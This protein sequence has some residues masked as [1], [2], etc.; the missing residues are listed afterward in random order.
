MCVWNNRINQNIIIINMIPLFIGRSQIHNQVWAVN[1]RLWKQTMTDDFAYQIINE[2]ATIVSQYIE[3]HS[4]SVGETL[5]YARRCRRQC[6]NSTKYNMVRS[7]CDEMPN[8]SSVKVLPHWM[9]AISKKCVCKV[10][11]ARFVPNSV[12]IRKLH[13]PLCTCFL[14]SI[15]IKTVIFT[16]WSKIDRK[17]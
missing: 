16:K 12:A 6:R 17:K 13:G 15:Q 14:S 2:T 5:F 7:W 11:L 1:V 10:A 3:C 8:Y 9:W 4:R